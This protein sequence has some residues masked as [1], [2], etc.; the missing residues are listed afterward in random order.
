MYNNY[1]P[2][3]RVLTRLMTLKGYPEKIT[4]SFHDGYE[5]RMALFDKEKKFRVALDE[6]ED[7]IIADDE[8]EKGA[9]K[10]P[11][12]DHEEDEEYDHAT[13]ANFI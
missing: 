7:K 9:T 13:S 12:A 5:Y 1:M 3:D 2:Q 8:A 10:G 4:N 6:L 11:H